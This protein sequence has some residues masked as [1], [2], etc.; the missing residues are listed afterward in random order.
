MKILILNGP[1]LNLIGQRE[2]DTYGS[3]TLLDLEKSL[4]D[5]FP[6]IHFV[7]HQS[8]EEGSLINKLQETRANE[9]DG[10]VLNAGGYTHSSVAIRDAIAAVDVPVV[11]VHISN[12]Y[13]RETFRH[14]SVIAAVCAGNI[15]GF[16][17]RS[18]H[19]GVRALIDINTIPN[20]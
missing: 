8:N 5:S 4:T 2:P 19:H 11:E 20:S 18:Y 6:S 13:A 10:V 16:G 12:V 1:N 14:K 17:L 7:F 3:A 9:I 15:S